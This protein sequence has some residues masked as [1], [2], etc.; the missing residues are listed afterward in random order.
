MPYNPYMIPAQAKSLGSL[1]NLYKS[2]N[3]L[4][5]QYPQDHRHYLPGD[6]QT[7]IHYAQLA[8]PDGHFESFDL[9]IMFVGLLTT[10]FN[11]GS[12]KIV[13][14]YS[15]VLRIMLV[16]DCCR[17]WNGDRWFGQR[18]QGDRSY[19][20]SREHHG[21]KYGLFCI[22]KSRLTKK[23]HVFSSGRIGCY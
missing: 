2:I 10:L 14:C 19:E 23:E 20:C 18:V 7:P 1:D 13:T 8:S 9:V 11:K 22:I 15:Q 17:Y 6:G 4:K 3:G 12:L 5:R 16:L 21:N